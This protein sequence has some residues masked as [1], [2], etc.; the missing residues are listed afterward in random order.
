[1]YTVWYCVLIGSYIA[2]SSI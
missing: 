1:M 2:N